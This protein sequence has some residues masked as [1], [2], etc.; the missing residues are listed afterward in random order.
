MKYLINR[1]PSYLSKSS[2]MSAKL[3]FNAWWCFTQNELVINF[4]DSQSALEY[5]RANSQ[6]RI[7]GNTQQNSDKDVYLPRPEGLRG[8]H[9]TSPGKKYS[10][11]LVFWSE[12]E[13]LAWHSRS[14]ISTI[15]PEHVN[16]KPEKFRT[17]VYINREVK[18]SKFATSNNVGIRLGDKSERVNVS[19]Q[20]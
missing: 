15:L 17:S 2:S 10:L 19:D 20:E 8:I 13:A 3:E 7:F 4:P 9:G 16:A 6:G 14:Q 11:I 1:R 18:R 12:R 5:Q